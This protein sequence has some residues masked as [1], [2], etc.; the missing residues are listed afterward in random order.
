MRIDNSGRVK[1]AIPIWLTLSVFAIPVLLFAAPLWGEFSY[2]NV[3]HWV[4]VRSVGL[5]TNSIILSATGFLLLLPPVLH[6]ALWYPAIRILSTS[7]LVNSVAM[8]SMIY[9]PWVF[10]ILIYAMDCQNK[11]ALLSGVLY[12]RTIGFVKH[13]LI[14]VQIKP[15]VAAF[16]ITTAMILGQNEVPELLG[17]PVYASEVFAL[18]VMESELSRVLFAALPLFLPSLLLVLVTGYFFV[19]HRNTML[20][21]FGA[22]KKP[23]IFSKNASRI[24][25][26]IALIPCCVI[27]AVLGYQMVGY[28]CSLSITNTAKALGNTLVYAGTS[29]VIG[30]FISFVLSEFI[31]KLGFGMVRKILVVCILLYVLPGLFTGLGILQLKMTFLS[32]DFN[33]GNGWLLY[34]YISRIIPVFLILWLSF[35]VEDEIR[36]NNIYENRLLGWMGRQRFLRLP[37]FRSRFAVFLLVGMTVL[38]SELTMTM[39][40]ISPGTETL[41]VRSYNLIHYGAWNEVF[42]ISM[43]YSG[44]IVAVFLSLRLLKRNG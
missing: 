26:P 17:F 20:G 29:S 1:Q 5:L 9:S 43:F 35:A 36:L 22:I 14:P 3:S 21:D 44:L 39:L 12:T 30:L 25:V 40:L 27:I 33:L 4:T 13:I 2:T 10:L 7:P 11:T 37:M 8:M 28:C 31:L 19:P 34:A 15:M 24:A 18:A 23:L 38:S 42:L 41:V 6:Y 32:S 16:A